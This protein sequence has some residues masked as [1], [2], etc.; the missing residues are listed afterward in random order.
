MLIF[1]AKSDRIALLGGHYT[2]CPLAIST[3]N[4]GVVVGV[5]LRQD[6]LC[7]AGIKRGLDR[8]SAVRFVPPCDDGRLTGARLEVAGKSDRL[9]KDDNVPLRGTLDRDG[10]GRLWKEN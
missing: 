8:V 1:R 2:D 6:I 7:A 9:E 3:L 10:H 4:V 5:V